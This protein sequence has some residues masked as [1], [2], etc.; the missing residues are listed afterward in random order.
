MK[1]TQIE[2]MKV[3]EAEEYRTGLGS[4]PSD[5]LV[6]PN[7]QQLIS[8]MFPIL[9]VPDL[10]HEVNVELFRDWDQKE[11]G[12]LQMLRYIRILSTDSEKPFVSR[13]GQYPRLVA[14]AKGETTTEVPLRGE[15]ETMDTAG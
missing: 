11:V 3:R 2:E 14:A 15:S 1:E 6:N 10:T 8:F 7:G 4:S 5:T 9:E 12:Y 13:P